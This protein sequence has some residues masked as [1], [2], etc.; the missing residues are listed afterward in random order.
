LTA[1]AQKNAKNKKTSL[2]YCA[3]LI[4]VDLSSWHKKVAEEL[5]ME[6]DDEG[7]VVGETREVM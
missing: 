5:N 7:L 1:F 4:P 3:Y 2:H 6:Y